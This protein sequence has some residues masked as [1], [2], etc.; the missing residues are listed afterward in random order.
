VRAS[1]DG[2]FDNVPSV[3]H[4][5]VP[6]LAPAADMRPLVLLLGSS[7]FGSRIARL[8]QA[9]EAGGAT[10]AE[11]GDKQFDHPFWTYFSKVTA[12]MATDSAAAMLRT[13]PGAFP[14]GAS[15]LDVAA[16][17]GGYGYT[18]AA[19][20][21]DLRV[22]LLDYPN[23]LHTS[24]ANA[25]ALGLDLPAAERAG[26]VA[27][28]EGSAFTTELSGPHSTVIVS[29]FLHHFT[30][31]DCVAFLRRARAAA[32]AGGSLIV[33]DFVLPS[34]SFSLWTE[35]FSF[36]RLFSAF[37][38]V[39]TRSGKVFSEQEYADMLAEAGWAVESSVPCFP[40]SH[41]IHARAV[42]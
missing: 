27:F 20:R 1:S 14:R 13:L 41:F 29:N 10:D 5:L 23:V 30:R 4:H 25:R 24:R 26:R 34:K 32:A 40:V 18:F 17:S 42:P 35:G 21:E 8:D 3:T 16:G 39:W 6:G 33:H 31:Q 7:E 22:T 15:V 9:L 19:L 2:L 38:L 36:A 12:P 11:T 28:I 37:M